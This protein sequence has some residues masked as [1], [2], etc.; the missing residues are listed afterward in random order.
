[1]SKRPIV[2]LRPVDRRNKQST[3]LQEHRWDFRSQGGEDGVIEKIF[4][5]IGTRNK[6]CVEFG[7]G[8]GEKLSNTF[9]L[10]Q[11]EGWGGV[12]IE[13]GGA[14]PRLESLYKHNK[15]VG[16]INSFVGFEEEIL[17]DTLLDKCEVEVPQ[18]L[19][20]MSIDIDGNDVH[21]WQD[22]K[23]YKPRV[24]CI[25]F[26]HMIGND[27][28][29]VQPRD[30]SIN[31]GS[32][33]LATTEIAKELGYELVATT[34]ANGLFVVREEYEK[35]NIEDNSIDAMYYPGNRETKLIQSYDGSLYLAGLK[36]NPWKGYNLDEERMQVLPTNMRQWKFDG[37]IFPK[38]KI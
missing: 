9:K 22:L 19:D 29:V 23:Q 15:K 7:A 34:N 4:E 14:Y 16:T 13:P 12:M 37:A 2:E 5:V 1:M 25:E 3:W 27:I 18:D 20:F 11:K 31:C 17:L 6:F 33:L 24:V 35:F 38:K 30:M 10:T 32:S 26:N 28:Y 36:K 8:D 21:V